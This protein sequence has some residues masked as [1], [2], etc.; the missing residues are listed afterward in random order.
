MRKNS[1]PPLI[2]KKMPYFQRRVLLASLR[3]KAL[4]SATRSLREQEMQH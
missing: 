4:E 2:K 1:R 3:S